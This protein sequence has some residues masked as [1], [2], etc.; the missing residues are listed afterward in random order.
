MARMLLVVL[1]CAPGCAQWSWV[2]QVSRSFAVSQVYE[3]GYFN[4]YG[5][6]GFVCA[7]RCSVAGWGDVP[8]HQ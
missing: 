1:L 6:E 4:G 2:N 7:D 5:R 3:R 8:S